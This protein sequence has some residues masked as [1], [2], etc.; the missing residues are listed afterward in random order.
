M[1]EFP[2]PAVHSERP[3][4]RHRQRRETAPQ[5][6]LQ[7]RV[8]VRLD[9]EAHEGIRM[10]TRQAPRRLRRCGAREVRALPRSQRDPQRSVNTSV[11]SAA[12]A[13]RRVTNPKCRRPCPL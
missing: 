1:P 11:A 2:E 7:A 9:A 5:A 8:Q 10:T 3:P 13:T 6:A 12:T 4:V